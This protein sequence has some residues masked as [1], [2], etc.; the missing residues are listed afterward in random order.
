[1]EYLQEVVNKI[2]NKLNGNNN[3][4]SGGFK[5]HLSLDGGYRLVL[6]GGDQGVLRVLGDNFHY[7]AMM[8]LLSHVEAVTD[9]FIM[10]NGS[11]E[12][13]SR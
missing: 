12:R 8:D 11:D 10:V 13:K 1:M 4:W 7:D 5:Y 9:V 2:N 6:L 3:I